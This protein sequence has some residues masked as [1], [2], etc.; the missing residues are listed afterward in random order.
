MCQWKNSAV[1]RLD[2]LDPERQLL[3]D[4]V[5]E[6]NR[7]LL[8]EDVVDPKHT[9]PGAL[10]DHGSRMAG[11]LLSLEPLSELSR[12]SGAKHRYD[13]DEKRPEGGHADPPPRLLLDRLGESPLPLTR[14]LLDLGA[15]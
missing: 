4:V 15:E 9:E 2:Q 14:N 13:K 12:R 6:L 8:V 3:E 7:D 1:V 5:D 10:I 11:R